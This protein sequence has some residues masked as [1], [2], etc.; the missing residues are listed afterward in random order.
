MSTVFE[1]LKEKINQLIKEHEFNTIIGK[2]VR[3]ARVD[4]GLTQDELAELLHTNRYRIINFEQGK[5]GLTPYEVFIICETLEI[6]FQKLKEN[7]YRKQAPAKPRPEEKYHRKLFYLLKNINMDEN[8]YK[9]LE[10]TFEFIKRKED[11]S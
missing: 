3:D 10:Q 8:T 4:N 9:Y 7:I 2:A 11:K 6:P 1:I 5:G